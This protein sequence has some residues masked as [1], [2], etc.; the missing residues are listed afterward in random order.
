MTLN[1]ENISY[2]KGLLE[3]GKSDRKLGNLGYEIRIVPIYGQRRQILTIYPEDS[4]SSEMISDVADHLSSALRLVCTATTEQNGFPYN[5]RVA[6]R[7]NEIAGRNLFFIN[8][9]EDS[10]VIEAASLKL[11]IKGGQGQPTEVY[12][13]DFIEAY[14]RILES[15]SNSN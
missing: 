10:L 14:K 5:G 12:I 3:Q 8:D 2:L 4:S 9:Q 13:E 15:E 11:E 7:I 1:D 6:Y